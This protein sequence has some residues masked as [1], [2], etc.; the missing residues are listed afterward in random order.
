MGLALRPAGR[1]L[2]RGVI[3]LPSAFTVGNLFLG[4]WAIVAASRGQF[5]MAGW[6]IVVA[7][8]LDML[9]GR[10]A[11]F[12]STSS[13]F[14]EQLDSL[15]D[16]VS[17]GVA[18][19]LI[20]YFI[21][22]GEGPWSW[23]LSFVYV[24]AV[25]MRLARFN[26]EQ[27]GVAKSNFHGLPSPTA[28]VTV[29]TYY[30]FSQTPFFQ[31]YLTDLPWPALT[32]GLILAVSLLMVSHVLYP[33]V[34]RFS[35]RTRKGVLTL[36]VALIAIFLAFTAP[37]HFFFPAAVTYITFGLLRSVWLGFLDRLPERDPLIDEEETEEEPKRV[38]EY[39]TLDSRAPIRR[40]DGPSEESL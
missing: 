18:P 40:A 25:I 33:V 10:I 8:V 15:V 16:A 17:F 29:A 9:D 39:D 23:M 35:L 6:L 20:F 14:G 24:V 5:E 11:R 27:G 38:I 2:Q 31:T 12:T 3:I 37:S 21:Y 7:A 26:I 1:R 36:A 30:P 28:G 34:P 13:A 19:A 32:V 4:F 22:L